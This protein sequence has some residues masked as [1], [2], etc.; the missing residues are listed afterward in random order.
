MDGVGAGDAA[1]GQGRLAG[2][3]RGPEEGGLGGEV[4]GNRLVGWGV[5]ARSLH[6]GRGEGLRV[7]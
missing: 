1:A 2:D 7:R 3:D 4:W 5:Q 6:G